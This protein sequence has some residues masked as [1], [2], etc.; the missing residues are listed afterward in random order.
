MPGRLAR[1]LPLGRLTETCCMQSSFLDNGD[2]DLLECTV[3]PA[4]PCS[5]NHAITSCGLLPQFMFPLS[6]SQPSP[7]STGSASR[8]F[9][10]SHSEPHPATQHMR[11][12]GANSCSCSGVQCCRLHRAQASFRKSLRRGFL[13]PW[14]HE[15]SSESMSSGHMKLTSGC[16]TARA[17]APTASWEVIPPRDAASMLQPKHAT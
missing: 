13:S 17:S 7:A 14:R 4:Q 16:V 3:I 12:R 2:M 15:C 1:H 6:P 11:K 10:R 8:S 9:N 5:N